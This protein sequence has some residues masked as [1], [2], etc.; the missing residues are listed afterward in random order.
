MSQ[1]GRRPSLPHSCILNNSH[2]II[3]GAFDAASSFLILFEETAKNTSAK[4]APKDKEQDLLRAMLVFACAGL[5]SMLKQLV[6]DALG[7][8]ID[9][10]EGANIQFKRYVEKRLS[11]QGTLDQKFLSEVLTRTNPRDALV[12]ELVNELTSKSLQSKNQILRTASYFDI[13]SSRITSKSKS[14]DAIFQCRN[15]ISHE[16]DVDFEQ[17]SRYRRPR[18]K[19][20]MIEY[21]KDVLELA[22]N[23]LLEIDDALPQN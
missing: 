18:Q 20:T 23:I 4:G 2:T 7:S 21:T 6:R 1:L 13:E 11:R 16:L 10:K 5:D 15:Q 14:L 19:E 9:S 12:E 3:Q 17:E 22:N 8:V